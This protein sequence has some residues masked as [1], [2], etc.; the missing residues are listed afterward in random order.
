MARPIGEILEEII[1]KLESKAE[2]IQDEATTDKEQGI[3]LGLRKAIEIV[4]Q[5]HTT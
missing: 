5:T 1:S 2:R 3:V 4:E